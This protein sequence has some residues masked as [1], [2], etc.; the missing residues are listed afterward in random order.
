MQPHAVKSDMSPCIPTGTFGNCSMLTC[1]AMTLISDTSR[2]NYMP[3]AIPQLW[4]NVCQA[5]E[6]CSASKFSEKTAGSRPWTIFC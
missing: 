6:L 4:V 3:W 2:P 1:W 5:V